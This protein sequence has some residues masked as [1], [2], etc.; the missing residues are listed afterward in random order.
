MSVHFRTLRSGS[1]GNA[2]LLV[3]GSC[4]V[5]ID[6]GLPANTALKACLADLRQRG[7]R[8]LGALITHEHGDHFAPGPLRAMRGLGLPVYAPARAISH[9]TEQLHLGHWGGRPEFRCYDEGECW[10]RTF[11]LGPFTIRPIEVTH[12]PGGSCFAFDIRIEAAAGPGAPSVEVRAVIAT[13]LCDPRSLPAALIDAD[14]IYLESNYDPMLLRL[15]PNP[16]SHFHLENARCGQLLAAARAASTLPPAHVFL[17]HLSE[18]R[19][20]P[21]LA[22][23]A[24]RNAFATAGLPLDFPLTPAP[25]YLPSPW[26]HVRP[27]HA[28]QPAPV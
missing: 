4:A 8:L 15:R 19:N 3:A 17:G 24:T 7:I 1:S 28:R 23:D 13:D 18:R 10:E 9:A 12:H 16:A 5:L 27:A 6:L 2:Q 21:T 22:L 14:L 26:T 20:T 25:R 11:T